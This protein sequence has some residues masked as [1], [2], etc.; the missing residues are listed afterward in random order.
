MVLVQFSVNIVSLEKIIENVN[1][2]VFETTEDFKTK[3]MKR[4]TEN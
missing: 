4:Q 1:A 3:M 2:N